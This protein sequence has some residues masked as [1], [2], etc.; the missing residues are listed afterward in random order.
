MINLCSDKRRRKP[1]HWAVLTA[2]WSAH[3][4]TQDILYS[5]GVITRFLNIY[6]W[7]WVRKH[8]AVAATIVGFKPKATKTLATTSCREKW[9]TWLWSPWFAMQ[10]KHVLY[11]IKYV[12]P[13]PAEGLIPSSSNSRRKQAQKVSSEMHIFQLLDPVQS[14]ATLSICCCL[15]C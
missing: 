1:A 4:S 2:K 13:L 11:N 9:L 10:L 15:H 7:L 3:R 12:Q 5:S 8:S 6:E 14:A